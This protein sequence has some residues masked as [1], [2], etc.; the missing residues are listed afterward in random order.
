MGAHKGYVSLALARRVGPEGLVVAIE[1]SRMNHWFLERH[2][3]W[4]GLRNVTTLK[5]AV[6]DRPGRERFGGA[7]STLAFQLGRGDETVRVATLDELVERDGLPAPDVVELDTEGSELAAL[8]GGLKA[9]GPSTVLMAAMHSREL[10]AGCGEHLRSRGFSV[11]PSDEMRR[12]LDDPA[13]PWGADH[14]FVAVGPERGA[15]RRAIGDLPLFRVAGTP[16]DAA[17]SEPA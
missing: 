12:R 4:N 16:L 14:D 8:A 15:M 1:P 6:G 2:V 11:H 13:L 10:C 9:L 7:G 17:G 5:C 3:A